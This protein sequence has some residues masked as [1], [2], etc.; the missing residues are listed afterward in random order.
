MKEARIDK[1]LLIPVVGLTILGLILIASTSYAVAG[2]NLGDR[3][4]YLKRHIFYIG[5]SFA[6]FF[7]AQQIKIQGLRKL[8]LPLFIL[9]IVLLLL[10]I[11]SPLGSYAGGAYR[12]F[13]IGGIRFQP[14]E[15]ARLAMI[16]FTAHIITNKEARI[17]QFKQ[18]LLQ[19][20][21]AVMIISLLVLCEPDFGSAMSIGITGLA[22]LYIGGARFKHLFGFIAISLPFACY[23]ILGS[24]YRRE[25]LLAF[26]NP[27]EDPMDRGFQIIQSLIAIRS[28]G[29]F[30]QGIGDGMQKFFYLPEAHN[31][32]AFAILA[33]ELG[34][35]GVAV[36]IVLFFMF[37]MR[38]M[39]IA[40]KSKNR[41]EALVAAGIVFSIAIQAVTNMGVVLGMLPTKGLTLPLISFGGTSLLITYACIG[42]LNRISTNS[43]VSA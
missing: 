39:T 5:I 22:L 1:M 34:F 24:V 30:G 21:L 4:F 7:I 29:F 8:A 41:F 43:G 32:F 33:E 15:F 14:S 31:D 27:W 38:G 10:T 17:T 11:A 36:V 40:A 26:L 23:A 25:R 42:I 18:G 13:K 9:S 12:W 28:G 19:P 20:L 35:I 3:Y 37:L 16:I 6:A 2:E